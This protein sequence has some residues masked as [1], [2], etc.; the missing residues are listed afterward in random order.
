L[1]LTNGYSTTLPDGLLR[2]FAVNEL[3]AKRCSKQYLQA[4]RQ[5]LGN[6]A[7]AEKN[8]SLLEMNLRGDISSERTMRTLI[9]QFN[10]A[11][12]TFRKPRTTSGGHSQMMTYYNG[13]FRGILDAADEYEMMMRDEEAIQYQRQLQAITSKEV[14]Y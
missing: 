4:L 1:K 12:I 7:Q 8:G 6:Q 10:E 11:G 2:D 13:R 14:P 9:D 5:V 3:G